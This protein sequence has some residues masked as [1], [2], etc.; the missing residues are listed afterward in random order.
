MS[1][2][3]VHLPN[4]EQGQL[5]MWRLMVDGQIFQHKKT[6]EGSWS[7]PLY[8]VWRLLNFY[9]DQDIA[10][11]GMT[12][13]KLAADKAFTIHSKLKGVIE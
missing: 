8:I 10:D 4:I 11:L 1:N 7:F 9:E 12:K 2:K 13:F 5:R 6:A 3:I